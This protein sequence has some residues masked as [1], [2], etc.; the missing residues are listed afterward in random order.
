MAL[1]SLLLAIGPLIWYLDFFF[2]CE[3]DIELN[4][5]ILH[6]QEKMDYSNLF[7]TGGDNK[8]TAPTTTMKLRMPGITPTKV[9]ESLICII[10]IID[11]FYSIRTTIIVVWHSK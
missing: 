9:I 5:F 11:T 1:L 6:L 2:N 3:N 7:Q 4:V 8:S 10:R